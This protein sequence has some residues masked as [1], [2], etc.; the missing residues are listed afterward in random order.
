MSQEYRKII[1]SSIYLL[2]TEW[3]PLLDM[4]RMPWTGDSEAGV[5]FK[6]RVSRLVSWCMTL[7]FL[8]RDSFP[9]KGKSLLVPWQKVIPA[10]TFSEAINIT[11]FSHPPLKILL[12][13]TSNIQENSHLKSGIKKLQK[14]QRVFVL[15]SRHLFLSFRI[16]FF[17][18][19]CILFCKCIWMEEKET[20]AKIVLISTGF[21]SK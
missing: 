9:G 14:E 1:L 10:K 19:S 5:N 4:K 15:L 20:S 7:L 16:S 11:I 18:P 13:H 2:R 8:T 21:E 6:T 17:R 12:L 3:C